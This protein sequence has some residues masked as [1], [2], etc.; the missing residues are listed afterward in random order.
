M[1]EKPPALGLPAEKSGQRM[2][3]ATGLKAR[4]AVPGADREERGQSKSTWSCSIPLETDSC[5]K[6]W[7]S[8]GNPAMAKETHKWQLS[9]VKST[10]SSVT[11]GLTSSTRPVV[12]GGGCMALQQLD[13]PRGIVLES[14]LRLGPGTGLVWMLGSLLIPLL[15]TRGG[16]SQISRLMEL[17]GGV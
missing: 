16:G 14:V 1:W 12:V 8:T 11:H 15:R 17:S 10:I 13:A 2:Q 4:S 9:S 7:T 3:Q 6:P 5:S